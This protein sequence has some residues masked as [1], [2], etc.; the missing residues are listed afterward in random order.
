MAESPYMTSAEAVDYLRARSIN[1]L[2]Q[3]VRRHH[4]PCLR[5]GNTYLFDKRDVD[6]WLRGTTALELRRRPRGNGLALAHGG[7][8]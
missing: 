3:L 1:N 5:R 6:A 2:Y 7:K 8:R 4:L